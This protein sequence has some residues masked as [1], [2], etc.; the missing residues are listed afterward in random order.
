MS[1]KEQLVLRCLIDNPKGLYGSDFLTVSK[2]KLTRGTI[3]TLL[4]RLVDKDLVE[5]VVDAPTSN[6]ALPRTRHLITPRGSREYQE[7]LMD[8]GLLMQAGAFSK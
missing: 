7:F 5:E 6:T 2:G 4:D 1:P 3:Y 8:H